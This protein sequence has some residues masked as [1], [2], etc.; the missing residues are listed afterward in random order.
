AL[1]DVTLSGDKGSFGYMLDNGATTMW[2]HWDKP[3]ESSGQNAEYDSL[4]HCMFGGGLTTWM[5]EGLGGI[6]STSAAY[7]TIIFRPG[8]ESELS[9]V[10]SSVDT[11]IGKAVSNWTYENDVLDWTVTV[12]VNSE[13]TIIIP[14]ADATVIQESGVNVFKKDGQGLT[15]VGMEDGAYVYTAGSGTYSFHV[16]KEDV[17][18]SCSV[19]AVDAQGTA[20][21]EATAN[22]LF[23]VVAVTPADVARV[24]LFNE[25]GLRMGLKE[26]QKADNGDGTVTWTFKMA[27]GTAGKGRTLTLATMDADGSYTM[28]DA[29]FTIDIAAVKPVIMSASI[30]ETATVNEP[31]KL[32]V[33]TNTAAN[34]INIYNEYGLKMGTMSQSYQD[35]DGERVWE[36]T[37][38]IGTK[39]VRTFTV[40]AKNSA[41]DVSGEVTTN[42]VVV[43]PAQ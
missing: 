31:V 36:V 39:G 32:T 24:A 29:S 14:I 26:L 21:T 41:G 27:I 7:H 37:M 38:A 13:A 17:K 22:E 40:S 12:P 11:M 23:D 5:F 42:E 30:E 43:T 6:K 16:T 1:M 10:N 2:E 9:S 8:L 35:I 15:Y 28:T 34:R 25:Y 3:G 33:V 20:L 18:P 4:N 19:Q